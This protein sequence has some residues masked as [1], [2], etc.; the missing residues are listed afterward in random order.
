MVVTFLVTND[1][2]GNDL[3]RHFLRSYARNGRTPG[4]RFFPHVGK[5]V[6]DRTPSKPLAQGHR[7][8]QEAV[9][10]HADRQ[11]LETTC[12]MQII[13]TLARKAY[14]RPITQQG[15]RNPDG[16]LSAWPQ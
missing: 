16:L 5:I 15:H 7:G 12:A 3:N 2:P 9:R 6:I 10:L 1:A 4:F 8:S 13:N 11:A 14:R